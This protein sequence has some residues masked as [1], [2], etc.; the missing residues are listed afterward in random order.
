MNILL[1][2]FFIYWA[3][4]AIGTFITE[5]NYILAKNK[6]LSSKAGYLIFCVLVSF[7]LVPLDYFIGGRHKEECEKQIKTKKNKKR[8]CNCVDT[9]F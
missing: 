5:S 9:P 2:M 8:K 7:L 1:K 6:S 4:C 3:I